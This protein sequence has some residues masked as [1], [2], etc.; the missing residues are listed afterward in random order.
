MWRMLPRSMR[1]SG[2]LQSLLSYELILMV[3]LRD[4]VLL[5]YRDC[6]MVIERGS[7]GDVC[8]HQMVTALDP[9]IPTKGLVRADHVIWLCSKECLL[10]S[11]CR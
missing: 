8:P 4:W 9:E 5:C 2:R 3:L 11:L 1:S 7:C 10:G 6:P